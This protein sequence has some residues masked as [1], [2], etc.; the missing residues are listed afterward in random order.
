MHG[1]IYDIDR[2]IYVKQ[3]AKDPESSYV[4]KPYILQNNAIRKCFAPFVLKERYTKGSKFVVHV[5]APAPSRICVLGADA[6]AYARRYSHVMYGRCH[7]IYSG[8]CLRN[9][10]RDRIIATVDILIKFNLCRRS[11]S[12]DR[13]WL[14][15]GKGQATRSLSFPELALFSLRLAA[16]S[17]NTPA[18][19][20]ELEIA[21]LFHHLVQEH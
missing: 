12:R 4:A 8:Q 9:L 14:R 5:H 18:A 6:F 19:F 1:R 7:R 3:P 13:M 2:N 15:C 10:A 16:V 20:P 17:H 11:C 21:V